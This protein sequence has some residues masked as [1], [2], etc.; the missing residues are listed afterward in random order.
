MQSSSSPK[1]NVYFIRFSDVSKNPLH[2][3]GADLLKHID[4]HL[5]QAIGNASVTSIV[6][7]GSDRQFSAGANLQ[8]LN[9]NV[10]N[11]SGKNKVSSSTTLSSI[12]NQG[13]SSLSILDVI[14]TLESCPKPTVAFIAGTCLGGGLELSLACHVRVCLPSAKLG[15][16][17]VHV[18]L[19]PGAGGTQRLPRLIGLQ[20]A[21][22]MI[23]TGKP[24]NAKKALQLGL[25]DGIVDEKD[26]KSC[27]IDAVATKW[28]QWAEALPLRRVSQLTC[29]ESLPEAH[30]MLHMAQLS[31]PKLGS[32]GMLGALTAMRACVQAKTFQDGMRVESEQF[33][34]ALTSPQGKARRHAFFAVRKAQQLRHQAPSNH[35]LLQ[36]D[37]SSVETAVIGAGTMGSGIALVLLRAGFKVVLVDVQEQALKRGMDFLQTTID[38][39]CKQGKLNGS[40]AQNMLQRLHSTMRLTDLSAAQL[41]IEAAIENMQIKQSIFKTLKEVTSPSALLVTNTSTLDV[42]AIGSAAGLHFFS[43]AHVMQLVEIV[44]GKNTTPATVAVLQLLTKRIGKIGVVVGNCD[45]FCGNRLL[46]P[47]QAETTMLLVEKQDKKPPSIQQVDAALLNF[48]MALGPFQ[49]SDLAGNDVGFNIRKERGWVRSNSNEPIPRQRPHRYSEL[50]DLM[51]SELGRNGQKVGKGWYDYDPAIGKGRKGF[52]S[53]EMETFLNRFYDASSAD[54]LKEMT[55]QE[56]VERV[57]FPLV[58]EGFK[59]LEEGIAR[60]PSDIDVIYLYGYGFPAWRGG[61]MYWADHEIG[62]KNLLEGLRRLSRQYPGTDHF[63]PSKL[64]ERCVTNGVT[65]DEYCQKSRDS[66]GRSKL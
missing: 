55:E 5:K 18:G 41:V 13:P 26:V 14:E 12:L 28:A 56:I 59:C 3:L 54:K 40:M 44:A 4:S 20:Q 25:V 27:T 10:S 63:I 47:Y 8:E 30:V 23:L 45:G 65:V 42:D 36:K 33:L 22:P 16:P 29:R 1:S 52:V 2:P 49:L 32:E 15:L 50:P 21:L 34:A 51:V 66:V 62:L 17:E 31:L 61:P 19:I 43:P 11:I 6:L 64:L 24:V 46:K 37:I 39:Q 35:P 53:R 58:N 60:E 57:L 38:T 48:G 9:A 7:M